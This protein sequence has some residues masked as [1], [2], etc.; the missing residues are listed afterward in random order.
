MGGQMS[1]WTHSLS[2]SHDKSPNNWEF[3]MDNDSINTVLI[4]FFASL[5]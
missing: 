3:H 2:L 4:N 1:P 5:L